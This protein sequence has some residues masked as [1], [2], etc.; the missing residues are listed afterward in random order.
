MAADSLSSFAPVGRGK[1]GRAGFSQTP[2]AETWLVP[3]G[4]KV[5]SQGGKRWLF[6]L[7]LSLGK[8][9]IKLSPHL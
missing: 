4:T 5:P 8:V 1:A 2:P 3:P 9:P 6:G 7:S